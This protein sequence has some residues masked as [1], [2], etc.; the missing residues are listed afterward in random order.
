MTGKTHMPTTVKDQCI[1]F[2][3]HSGLLCHNV[4]ESQEK[5]CWGKKQITLLKIPNIGSQLTKL[6]NRQNNPL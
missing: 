5:K 3:S 2:F 1:T 4:D 6:K